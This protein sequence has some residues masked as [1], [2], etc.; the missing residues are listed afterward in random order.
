MT[1]KCLN[2]RYPNAVF[3]HF[4]VTYSAQEESITNENLM[5]NYNDICFKTLNLCL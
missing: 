4:Q 1:V 2:L 5:V 3:A